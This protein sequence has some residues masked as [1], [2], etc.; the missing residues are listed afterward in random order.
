[1]GG[2]LVQRESRGGRVWGRDPPLRSSYKQ[3]YRK[4]I[5]SLSTW[6]RFV[7]FFV[8]HGHHS[9]QR[10][11]LLLF[12]FSGGGESLRYAGDETTIASDHFAYDHHPVRRNFI[13]FDRLTVKASAHLDY[14]DYFAQLA[15]DLN[16]PK[17]DQVVCKK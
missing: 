13:L 12:A 16:I 17:A 10:G 2:I 8:K 6:G 9:I 3:G 4:A 7:R 1:L 5:S 15:V 14:H 11:L